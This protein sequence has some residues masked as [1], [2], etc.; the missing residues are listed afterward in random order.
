M[1]K[2]IFYSLLLFLATADTAARAQPKGQSSSPAT[3]QALP[4]PPTVE[5]PLLA[6]VPAPQ[7]VIASWD[8]AIAYLRARSTDLR[9]ALDQVRQAEAQTRTAL[10]DYLPTMTGTGQYT[11]NILTNPS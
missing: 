9:I 11:H 5:D 8:Q 10:A 7:S 2:A 3:A 6:P 1:R 4:P